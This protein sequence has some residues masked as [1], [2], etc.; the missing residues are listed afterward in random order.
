MAVTK[1]AKRHGITQATSFRWR[2]KPDGLKPN[3][4]VELNQ[5]QR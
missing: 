4:A 2:K 1:V 5:L 3:Q